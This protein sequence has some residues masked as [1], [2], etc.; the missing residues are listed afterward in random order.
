MSSDDSTTIYTRLIK[1][2]YSGANVIVVA[3]PN[4]CEIGLSGI[5]LLETKRAFVIVMPTS[6]RKR[7]DRP[8]DYS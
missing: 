4:V 1:A 7:I 5:V 2:E 6:H 3:A 8:R